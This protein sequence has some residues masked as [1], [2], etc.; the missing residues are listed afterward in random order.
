M[1]KLYLIRHGITAGNLQ[2]LHYGSTDLPLAKEGREEIAWR[3]I[4]GCY[5]AAEQFFT[6]GLRRTEETLELIYGPVPHEQLPDLRE[7]DFGEYEMKSYDELKELPAYQAWASDPKG[8]SPCP[9]GESNRQ[10]GERILRGYRTLLPRLTKDT[11][12]VCH[13]GTIGTLLSIEIFPDEKK[14][15]LEWL[16]QPGG[17]YAIALENGAPVSWEALPGTPPR[18]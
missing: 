3:A 8:D 14:N 5:P 15:F 7:F 16:P 17:G 4:N 18:P 13:G 12:V 10:F 1:T 9:G 11:A 2:K 6:S